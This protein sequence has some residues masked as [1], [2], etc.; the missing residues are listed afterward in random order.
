MCL[1]KGKTYAYLFGMVMSG[2]RECVGNVFV[3][4]FFVFG[5]PRTG[6]PTR[7]CL[8]TGQ[9]TRCIWLVFGLPNAANAYVFVNA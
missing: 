2:K 4:C 5:I 9:Q 6:H 8:V 7:M 3:S 1:G